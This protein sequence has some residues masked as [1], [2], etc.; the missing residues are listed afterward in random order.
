VQFLR[1][2]KEVPHNIRIHLTGYSGLRPPSPAGDAD[3][4]AAS[5]REVC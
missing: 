5:G 2:F 4:W 1:F 3:R